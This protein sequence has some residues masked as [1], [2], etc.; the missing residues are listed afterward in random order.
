MNPDPLP[1]LERIEA[2]L[3]RVS[4]SPEDACKQAGLPPN[5]LARLREGKAAVPRGQRLIKLAQTLGTSVSY[6]V[7]LD[8]DV[9]PPQ[10]LLEE[11]QGSLGLLAGDEE[12]LLR[13]YRRLD[14]SA[15]AAVLLVVRQMAGPEPELRE[16]KPVHSSGRKRRQP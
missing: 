16:R 8:P 9:P 15:K 3:E 7:G 4:L 11:E 12:G 13:A 14:F 5:F 10:E 2:R 1:M 6:L